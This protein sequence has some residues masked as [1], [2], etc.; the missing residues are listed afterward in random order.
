M[1]FSGTLYDTLISL[2]GVYQYNQPLRFSNGKELS[3]IEYYQELYNSIY[4]NDNSLFR[5][6]TPVF[7]SRIPHMLRMAESFKTNSGDFTKEDV[8]FNTF[9]WINKKLVPSSYILGQLI[10]QLEQVG[11]GQRISANYTLSEP[12]PWFSFKKLPRSAEHTQMIEAANQLK[13]KYDITIDL[14]GVGK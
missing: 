14:S 3:N 12:A 4:A 10:T 8:Y 13:M 11:Q 2:F 1:H 7:N 5:R 9:Y 6:L